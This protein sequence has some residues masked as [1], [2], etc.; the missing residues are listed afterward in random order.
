VIWEQI[1]P[2]WQ[3]A[4][5]QAWIAYCAGSLP[6][7]A[8]L[9]SPDGEIIAQGRNRIYDAAN[10]GDPQQLRMHFMAHAEQ[11]TFVSLGFLMR[12]KPDLKRSL[13]GCTL[14]STLEPCIM[15]AGTLIQSGVKRVHYLVPD[16]VGG[17][18]DVLRTMP[19]LHPKPIEIQGP[20]PGTAANIV[21][22]FVMVMTTKAG[23]K[24]PQDIPAML[25]PFA[26]GLALGQLL[27]ETGE[28]EQFSA[29]QTPI[30]TVIDTLGARLHSSGK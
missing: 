13:A 17:A 10:D 2:P 4:I 6:I 9:V 30:S 5:E 15:C 3:A 25:L 23:M 21:L 29:Q 11:N 20:Q 12:E 26:D 1:P 18:I 14:Y 28:L 22:A 16:P 24:M 7:G 8:A 19:Q 27:S